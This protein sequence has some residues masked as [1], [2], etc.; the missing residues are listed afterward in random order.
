MERKKIFRSVWFWIVLVI[1][2]ALT[3]SSL[4]SGNGGFKE[5]STSAALAQIEDGN[6]ESATLNTKEQTLDLQ[7]QDEVQGSSEVRASYPVAVEGD[8]VNLLR[9]RD[10][11]ST[12]FDTNVTQD[13]L[14][15]SLLVSFLPFLILLL[16]LFWLFN[17]MQGGGRGV[18]AF[19]KDRKS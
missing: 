3:V 14:L 11:D 17:S 5:I 9:D 2:V 4:F 10:G 12:E 19:G 13:S 15:V 8:I 7:L 6:V 18:M 16:L 1:L